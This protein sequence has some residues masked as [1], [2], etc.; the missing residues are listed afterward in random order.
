MTTDWFETTLGQICN[1]QGGG[2]QTG[3]FGSQ[4]HTADYKS[5]GVPV[6]MPTNIS[7]GRI[8]ED[9]I[10]R[11]DELDVE[12]LGQHKLKLDDIVFSR[13]GDVTKNALIREYETGWLCGTGCL[14]VRLGDQTITDAKFISYYLRTDEIKNWLVRH[15]VGATMPNLNT[16]ILSAVPLKLPPKSLQLSIASMMGA[17]DDRINLIKETNT[18]LE[19]IAQTIF[20]SWFVDFDPI[21]A[22][23]QGVKSAGIDKAT[24]DLFPNSFVQSEFGLIPE[25]WRVGMVGDLVMQDKKTI[26]PAL[27][28][29]T[30]FDHYSLPAFDLDKMPSK[31]IGI[32]IKSNKTI[33]Q[34]S[35]TL[36]SKLNPKTPRVWLPACVN[37]NAVCSTEFI[38]FSPNTLNGATKHF[39]FCLLNDS[40]LLSALSQKVTGTSSS[41]QRI[42]PSDI[43]E[44]EF[45]VPDPAIIATFSKVIEPLLNKIGKNRLLIKDLD[46]IKNTLLPRL[47]SGKL[48]LSEIEEQLEGV[49]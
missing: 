4:L 21:H 33:V 43:T 37:D 38:P 49:A 30:V 47:M 31:D 36:V 27:Y 28:K 11:V 19:A 44:T 9:G 48:N 8:I 26:N 42:R 13:R 41:H 14:K 17:L 6:V 32:D 2:V 1:S 46:C 5:S 24:A 3:P 23:Q 7:D 34:A 16:S 20:K 15:A 12:R 40:A 10:A 25:G 35:S 45:V 39:V 29:D 22:R 18:T